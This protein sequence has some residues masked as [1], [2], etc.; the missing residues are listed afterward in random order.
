[1]AKKAY[2]GVP[3]LQGSIGNLAVGSTVKLNVNG[4]ATDF[5][6]VH[7]GNPDISIYDASCD[8]T[9]LLM[10]DIYAKYEWSYSED[11]YQESFVH[12]YLN[13]TFVGS[14]DGSVQAAIKQ[15]K[16]PH[17]TRFGSKGDQTGANGLSAKAFLLSV[18]EIT[19]N[20][21]DSSEVVC[22]NDGACLS[23]F[24]GTASSSTDDPKRVAHYG[25]T[26]TNW[27]LR[28]PNTKY[29]D[30]EFFVTDSGRADGSGYFL[31]NYGVRPAFIV[32]SNIAVI[33]GL[34][35]G[36]EASTEMVSVARKIKKGYIGIDGVARKIKKA[37]IGDEN[38]IA[39]LVFDGEGG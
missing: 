3:G 36:S 8:G 18:R 33:N 13:T 38:G 27:W 25:G 7:H 30:A 16:I 4:A 15:V 20:A 32:P 10:K 35:D 23:Y 29:S 34:V 21:V 14:L 26:A 39:R 24:S 12:S 22:P 5:V 2:I 17:T 19:Q 9:W 1:M 6:I 37:Y 11:D 28:S 31:E